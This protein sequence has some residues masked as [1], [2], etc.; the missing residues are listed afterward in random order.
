MSLTVALA[1]ACLPVRAAYFQAK[2]GMLD[3]AVGKSDGVIFYLR[4]L[5]AQN[6]LLATLLEK[7]VSGEMG[8]WVVRRDLSKFGGEDVRLQLEVS[9]GP[10][11]QPYWDWAVWYHPVVKSA[12][13]RV[14]LDMMK[15]LDDAE[16]GYILGGHETVVGKGVQYDVRGQFA[17][18]LCVW[19]GDKLPAP[20]ETVKE[21]AFVVNGRSV[22]TD[23]LF[24]HP[25]SVGGVGNAFVRY[26]IKLPEG[27]Q[28]MPD[29][30]TK[31]ITPRGF[32]GVAEDIHQVPAP[33]K[34]APVAGA[35]PPVAV[36]LVAMARWAVK[37]LVNNPSKERGYETRFG[38][39]P[40]QCP[41]CAR[42]GD[43]DAIAVGDTENRMDWEFVFMREMT[44]ST[45]GREVGDAIW[46]RILG[47][48]RDD[49]LSWVHSYCLFPSPE[50]TKVCV[51][52]WTTGETIVSLVERYRRGGDREYLKLAGK[53]VRGL[54]KLAT[55]DTGR[56]YLEGGLDGWLDGHWLGTNACEQYPSILEPVVRYWETSH[57]PEALDFAR[58]FADGQVA[59]LQPRLG[60]CRIMADG[61]FGGWNSH[62]HMRPV[63]GVAH[64]GALLHEPRYLDWSKKVYE[65]LRSMG[66]DWGW[67][68]ESPIPTHP[69]SETCNEADMTDVALWLARGGFT[70][71]W[72]H[73]ERYVRNYTVAAQWFLE[74]DYEALYREVQKANPAGVEEGLKLMRRF[75]GGFYACLTPAGKAWAR[76]PGGMNMMGCCPPE[77]MRT[78]YTAWANT[79]LET[80]RG[81]EVNMSF[82]RDHPAARVISFLP[83][84]GRL[85]VI[86]KKAADYYLRPPFW[87]PRK[88]VKAYVGGKPVDVVWAGDYIRFAAAKPKQELTMTYPLLDFRQRLTVAGGEYTYHWLG[89][90]VMGV[91]PRGILPIFTE[92]PRPL[93]KLPG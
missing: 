50:M 47:Y 53:M 20:H 89:N 87:A 91:E 86:A 24:T 70:E 67:F 25:T 52:N 69:F 77:G 10:A 42:P 21:S 17:H 66:T 8:F 49:G 40:L 28:A 19:R 16:V 46:K 65:Y 7:P 85:T 9:A 39:M 72:D 74:P 33:D 92:V 57:D 81:V 3:T 35:N 36:D 79:V 61:S 71:Y 27:E 6:R 88:A 82:D 34:I 59:D 38:I 44:G 60:P 4:V 22:L 58:A 45:E 78:L 54:K 55:F 56:A 14:L 43:F 68:P 30:D 23:V 48:V 2:I 64:L 83:R 41:P 84:E 75:E 62:L 93:P 51:M 29:E 11:N 26:A 12:D 90:T 32:R 18:G 80:D 5:D 73:V 13:G 37:Y 63:L 15:S 76:D 1:A 31:E